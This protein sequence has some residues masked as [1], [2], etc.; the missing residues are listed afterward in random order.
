MSSLFLQQ[1]RNHLRA[2]QYSKR[3]EDTYIYW[4]GQYIRS[5]SA[6]TKYVVSSPSCLESTAP[7][8][9]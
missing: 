5:Y 7:A 2:R 3:T 8:Q 6:A 4:I 1:V 9:N